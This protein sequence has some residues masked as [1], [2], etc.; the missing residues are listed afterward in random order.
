MH[1]QNIIL[2]LSLIDGIGPSLLQAFIQRLGQDRLSEIYDFFVSDFMALGVSDQ[3]AQLLVQGLKDRAILEQE[4]ILMAQ[5]KVDF[6]TFCCFNYPALLKEIHVPPTILYFQGDVKLFA[7][8]K[9]IACVGARKAHRYA[10]EALKHLIVPMIENGWMVVSGGALGA[11]AFA[12]QISL[13]Y[14]SPTVVVVGSGLC[15]VYPLQNAKLFENVVRA[16]GLIVS[17]FAMQTPPDSWNFPQRNRLISG[18]SKGCLVLQA[19]QKSGALITAHCALEQGREVFA[20]PGS[21]FDILS[22]GCHSLIGQGA[23]LVTCA[24]DIL[25]EFGQEQLIQAPKDDQQSIFT[26]AV[27]SENFDS[28]AVQILE[29]AADAITVDLMASKLQIDLHVLQN[30]LFELSLDGKIAQDAMGFWKRV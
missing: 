14:K 2:H 30:K 29:V 15:H 28:V 9:T 13:D 17:A 4:L 1:I 27:I 8:E 23:K 12:H 6:I 7:H 18:L 3:K 10:H 25:D 21:I 24:Q 22:A 11:D 26:A 20:V 19:A 16:G 5:H